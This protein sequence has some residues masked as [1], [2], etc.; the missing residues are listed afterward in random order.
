MTKLNPCP[1]C[2]S[3]AEQVSATV[4]CKNCIMRTPSF[5][6]AGLAVTWWNELGNA[7]PVVA[8]KTL[9]DEFAMAVLTGALAANLEELDSYEDFAVDAYQ[10]ADAMLKERNK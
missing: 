9:R 7:K 10:Q 3:D 1:V 6:N 5:S 8:V 2:E 4:Q